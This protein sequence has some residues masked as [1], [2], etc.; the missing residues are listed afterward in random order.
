[1]VD[2]R[3]FGIIDGALPPRA[4]ALAVEWAAQHQA[5]V[6]SLWECAEEKKSLWKLEPLK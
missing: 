3:T 1:L 2:I 5:D 6:M 4:L